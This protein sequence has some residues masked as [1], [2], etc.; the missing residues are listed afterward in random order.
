MTGSIP[1]VRVVRSGLEESVHLGDVA[2]CD[3]D[4][5]LLA[6]GGD[7]R[8]RV[9]ARSCMKPLQAAVSLRAMDEE[10]TVRELAVMCSSHNGEP[11]HVGA[12]RGLL[13]RAGLD[14]SALRCPP[15]WPLDPQSMARSIHPHRELSDCSGKHAGML[16]ACVEADWDV[17]TYE[18]ASHP[19]QHRVLRA[20]LRGTDLESVRLGVD[21]CGVPVHGMPLASMATLYARL[22][23]PERF[24]Y[25][26]A[27][28][29]ACVEAMLAEPYMVGGRD[30]VDTAIMTETGDV[31]VKGGAEALYCAGVLSSGI[32]IAAKIADGGGRAGRAALL[33]TLDLL[34]AI[35][36]D[37]LSALEPYA[38]PAVVGGDRRVGDLVADFELR[39]PR[40]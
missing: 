19:L 30:R 12:V 22:A 3:E 24:G 18:R 8:R 35:S 7:P 23:R 36:A 14:G 13:R 38:R 21:G 16:L 34:G 17:S 20:V 32:G 15:D 28:V 37:Q 27:Q 1:L 5:R 2:V 4:G 6:S 11:V 33:R 10:V 40:G 25:L 29:A 9:F 31:V 26:E 39:R